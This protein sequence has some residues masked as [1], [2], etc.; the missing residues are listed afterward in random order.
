MGTW[1]EEMEG[2]ASAVE[3]AFGQAVTIRRG[4]GQPGGVNFAT[5]AVA[6]VGVSEF[7]VQANVLP[8]RVS[9]LG[10]QSSDGGRAKADEVVL[11]VRTT[12]CAFI[13]REGDLV[14]MSVRTGGEETATVT[15]R[16]SQP[17]ERECDGA[18]LRITA[19]SERR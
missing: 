3:G 2:L 15:R 4:T 14:L 1:A 16:V 11:S 6:A 17:P 19:R 8:V 9:P 10:G 13:P 7:V 12:S 18:M 5:G